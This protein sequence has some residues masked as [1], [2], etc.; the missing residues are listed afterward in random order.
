MKKIVLIAIL[1]A[2]F[3]A[4][5]GWAAGKRASHC[6]PAAMLEA[7]QALRFM[8]QLGIASNTCTTIAIYA[9]FRTRNRDAIVAYQKT[10]IAHLHGNAAFDRWNTSLANQLAQHQTGVTPAQFCEQS[11]PMLKQA[12]TLDINGFRAYAAAQAAAAAKVA[13]CAK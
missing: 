2:A 6:S 10:M 4:P 8:T 3:A 7:E 13:N 5:P 11:W 12:S 9:G 1:V